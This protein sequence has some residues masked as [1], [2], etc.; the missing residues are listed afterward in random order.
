MCSFLLSLII[1]GGVEVAPD[2]YMVQFLDDEVVEWVI[3]PTTRAIE[4]LLSS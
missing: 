2:R 1:V 4:C 3:V